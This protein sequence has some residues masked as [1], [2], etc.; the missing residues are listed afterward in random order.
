LNESGTE[1]SIRKISIDDIRKFYTAS[2][3]SQ[4]TKIVVV[5]DIKQSEIV[6]KLAFLDKLPNKKADFTK[7]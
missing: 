3:T 4:G 6:P 1:N 5:G 7:N 2:L